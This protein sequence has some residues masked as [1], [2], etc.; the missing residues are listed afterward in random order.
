LFSRIVDG[1]ASYANRA[2][3]QRIARNGQRECPFL[4]VSDFEQTAKQLQHDGG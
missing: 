3:P 2:A 1:L 4:R